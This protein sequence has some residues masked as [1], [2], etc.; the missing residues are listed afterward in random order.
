MKRPGRAVGEGGISNA[1]IQVRFT[2]TFSGIYHV[3]EVNKMI[4]TAFGVGSA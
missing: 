2:T 3:V 4:G 1:Q